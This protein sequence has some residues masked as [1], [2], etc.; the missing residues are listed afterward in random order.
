MNTQPL[1]GGGTILNVLRCAL[2]ISSGMIIFISRLSRSAER[3]KRYFHRRGRCRKRQVQTL[4]SSP[5]PSLLR[6]S[7]SPKGRGL[8]MAVQFPAQMQSARSR[9]R[10]PPR[11]SWQSCQALTEGVKSSHAKSP[12]TQGAG[13]LESDL[14]CGLPAGSRSSSGGR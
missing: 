5:S 2:H 13:A 10:L 11:G 4:P 7:T 8:G 14:T 6:K 3:S 9:Q 12:R 1:P